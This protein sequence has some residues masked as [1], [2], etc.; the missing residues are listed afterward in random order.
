[1]LKCEPVYGKG[2]AWFKG[3]LASTCPS[4]ESLLRDIHARCPPQTQCGATRLPGAQSTDE[5]LTRGAL[6][7]TCRAQPTPP[8]GSKV[9]PEQ[10]A[11]GSV[12]PM[13]HR[14][15]IVPRAARH[16]PVDRFHDAR[17]DQ[18][19]R[20]AKAPAPWAEETQVRALAQMRLIDL[21]V[22]G[23]SGVLFLDDGPV[24]T[25]G[26]IGSELG[27]Q[28]RAEGRDPIPVVGIR[29]VHPKIAGGSVV[30]RQPS[31]VV[32]TRVR[33]PPVSKRP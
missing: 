5:F 20:S 30:K 11:S 16:G 10:R 17:G 1:M 19:L 22:L 14:G 21:V 27:V 15:G 26:K 7:L 13:A 9:C 24:D 32:N 4:R 23:P 29:S 18:R 28:E 2:R 3:G 31:G 33:G 12:E 6:A 8:H 25:R